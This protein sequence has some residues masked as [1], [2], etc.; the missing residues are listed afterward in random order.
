M[1]DL[2]LN[3]VRAKRI[4][5]WALHLQSVAEMAPWY[6]AYDHLNYARYLLAYIYEILA[7][8]DTH[9]SA[10]EYLAVKDFIVQQQNQ[11]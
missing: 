5:N 2:F 3:F 6:F 7:V 4:E 9:P 11:Y 10:E 8:P 1:A